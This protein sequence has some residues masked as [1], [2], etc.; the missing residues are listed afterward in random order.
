MAKKRVRVHVQQKARKNCRN[1]EGF[2]WEA[3]LRCEWQ[4]VNRARHFHARQP[5][6]KLPENE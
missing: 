6:G 3:S 1:E 5:N 2:P 4:R